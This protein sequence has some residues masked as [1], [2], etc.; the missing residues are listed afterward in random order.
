MKI[1]SS[2]HRSLS[3][4]DLFSKDSMAVPVL[5][6]FRKKK[7]LGA[8]EDRMLTVQKKQYD[9]ASRTDDHTLSLNTENFSCRIRDMS[10]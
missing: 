8:V 10:V 4:P 5:P 3:L 9:T 1:N 2:I 7:N 6:D